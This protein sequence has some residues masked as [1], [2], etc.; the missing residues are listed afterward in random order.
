MAVGV[1]TDDDDNDVDGGAK[2]TNKQTSK[3]YRFS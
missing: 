1:V 3:L 2:Q